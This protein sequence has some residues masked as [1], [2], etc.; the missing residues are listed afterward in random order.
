MRDKSI[1]SSD[2]LHKDY[3][4]KGPVAKKNSDLE[5]R[6]AWLVNRQS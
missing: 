4:R 3:G 2:I 5:P 1:L 6:G